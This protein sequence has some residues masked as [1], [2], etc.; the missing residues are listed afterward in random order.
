MADPKTLEEYNRRVADGNRITGYGMN[1]TVH[2]PCP[3]CGAAGHREFRL[4]AMQ[5]ETVK[6]V[7]CKECGRTSKMEYHNTPNSTQFEI[8]QTAGPPAPP[9]VPVRFSPDEAG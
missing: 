7:T 5:E 3:L 4:L 9:F 8:V 2:S 1:V 6:P